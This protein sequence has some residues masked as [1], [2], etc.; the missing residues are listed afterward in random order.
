MKAITIWQPWASLL[1]HGVKKFETRG[2][3]TKY[4]GP[5]AIH[6]AL[7]EVKDLPE[8]VKELLRDISELPSG[9]II[10]TAELVNVW[11]IVYN[12]GADVDVAKNI[13][14]GAESITTDKRAPDFGDYFVPTK[15]EMA[16]GDWT[17]GRYA[18]ELQN[19]KL[20][21]E[22]VKIKGKQGLWDWKAEKEVFHG[23]KPNHKGNPAG[24]L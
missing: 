3:P 22:P 9:A 8:E 4:R 24:E 18:W 1:A 5:I 6:A 11:Y 7:K 17:P 16:L 19:V 12:P 20:L 15:Q 2:W 21:S 23:N 10:A 13:P 14:I